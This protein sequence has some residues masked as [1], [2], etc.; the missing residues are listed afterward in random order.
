VTAAPGQTVSL[1]V[2]GTPTAIEPGGSYTG[3]LV[4][5]VS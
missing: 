1:T 2:N 5:T 4:L 3:A